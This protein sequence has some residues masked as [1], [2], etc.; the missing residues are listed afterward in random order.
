MRAITQLALTLLCLLPLGASAQ[1]ETYSNKDSA[2]I[3]ARRAHKGWKLV[4]EDEFNGNTLDQKSWT[5]CV[6]GSPDWQKHMS[7]ELDS[8]V[9]VKDGVLQLHA[10]NTPEGFKDPLNRPQLT[11]GVD[12]R[13]KRFIEQGLYEVRLRF[14]CAIG[15]WPAAWLMPNCNEKW[16]YAGEVDIMEHLNYDSIA[17]QTLHSIHTLEKRKPETTNGLTYRINPHVFNTY[18]V[19]I[20]EDKVQYYINGIPTFSYSRLEPEVDMQY[21][22]ADYPYYIILSAQLGGHWVGVVN[23]KEMPVKMEVDYVRFYKKKGGK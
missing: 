6:P 13:N 10:I 17:Y 14:D 5:R 22:F 21:P 4:W 19:E 8:L 18:T 3:S 20:G 12:S 11:G 16:P 23:P 2:K 15:F 7:A 9:T 1:E